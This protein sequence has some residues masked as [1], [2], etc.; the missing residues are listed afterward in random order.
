MGA[1]I[2]SIARRCRVRMMRPR[3]ALLLGWMVMVV[4]VASDGLTLLSAGSF[5]SQ[6]V[7][8]R[9]HELLVREQRLVRVAIEDG[10]P[11]RSL[12]G[13]IAVLERGFNGRIAFLPV[14]RDGRTDAGSSA[15]YVAPDL[16]TPL[17]RL[18][19]AV[20]R[21]IEIGDHGWFVLYSPVERFGAGLRK[22]VLLLAIPTAPLKQE[23]RTERDNLLGTALLTLVLLGYALVGLSQWLGNQLEGREARLATAKD[24]LELALAHMSDGLCVF[25]RHNRMTVFNQQFCDILGL[26]PGS[27]QRGDSF[28]DVLALSLAL[29]NHPGRE[30]TEVVAELRGFVQARRAIKVHQETYDGRTIETEY[31]PTAKG[32]WLLTC[33]DVTERLRAHG[34][35]AYMAEH[36]ALTGLLNR[37]AFA[38]HLEK[39]VAQA[40]PDRPVTLLCLD[41]DHFKDVNDCWGHPAGDQLLC[42]VADRLRRSIRD[43]EDAAYRLGG[44]E[45]AVLL[46][47][48]DAQEAQRLARRMLR[49]INQH[50]EIAGA[51]HAP[52]ASIGIAAAPGDAAEPDRLL[53][54][55]DLALYAAKDSGRNALQTYSAALDNQVTGRAATERMLHAALADH[56]FELLYQ[57]VLSLPSRQLWGFEALLR[58]HHPE[59]GLLLPDAFVGLA[60]KTSAI[61]EIGAWAIAEACAEAAQ[62]PDPIGLAVNVSAEQLHRRELAAHVKRVLHRT[63]VAPERLELEVTETAIIQD[64]PFAFS[65]LGEMQALGVKVVLDDFGTG[66][67]SLSF[68][69]QFRFDSIKIDRSFVGDIVE[70]PDCAAIVDALSS[71]GSH[72]GLT[73]TAEGIE[74][75]DQLR[76][77]AE[78]GC[79]RAQGFLL[80]LPMRAEEARALACSQRE[81]AAAAA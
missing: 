75:P 73:T 72:L 61:E 55:A 71:L 50:V 60:E 37:A 30:P 78:L 76:R 9:A 49:T 69:T 63:G 27:V 28:E 32:G 38:A 79:R 24:E 1:A 6:S 25:D 62:W 74:T 31:S 48:I 51:S 70:R 35:I 36:D 47:G 65:V 12:T 59:R 80:G 7:P 20:F 68:L 29:G 18:N 15:E 19:H 5:I 26:P 57:P 13:R 22:G 10:D 42:T 21:Q 8:T 14:M 54:C 39:H 58:W 23:A 53:K 17:G 77:V 11:A 41:L 3:P 66:Y 67:S 40:T 44:D 64:P 2:R 16:P 56:Q 34:A 46:T 52:R 45:F 81:G 4:V 33:A 43:G